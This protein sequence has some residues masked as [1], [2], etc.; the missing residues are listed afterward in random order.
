MYSKNISMDIWVSYWYNDNRKERLVMD[1]VF[2][3]IAS[4]FNAANGIFIKQYQKGTEKIRNADYVFNFIISVI[5]ATFYAVTGLFSDGISLRVEFIPYSMLYALCYVIGTVGYLGAVARGSLLITVIMGQMGCL[6]PIV[7]SI[8]V[9]GDKP[10]VATAIG[11]LLLFVALLLFYMQK[12]GNDVKNKRSFWP[13]AIMC[14]FGNGGAMLAVKM[15]QHDYPGEQQ[16]AFLFWG[17]IFAAAMFFIT[18]LIKQPKVISCGE[19]TALKCISSST[20]WA[21]LYGAFNAT[22]NF[23]N[24]QIISRLPTVAFYMC[25][26]GF[27]ILLSFIIARSIYREKLLPHQYIG[28]FVATVGLILLMAF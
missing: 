28:C 1:Y 2:C 10:T 24:A 8:I 14:F 27:G 23:I 15:Q 25:G 21:I 17:I 4:A 11:M 5:A 13:F 26:M 12:N 6:I 3:F 18:V 20:V 7:F 22:V 19:S 9:Y 16:S